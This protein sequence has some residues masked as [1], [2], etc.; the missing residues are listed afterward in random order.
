MR[1]WVYITSNKGQPGLIKV[2]YTDRDP[3]IRAGELGG[4]GVPQGRLVRKKMV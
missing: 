4:T 3:E 2:G 1:G